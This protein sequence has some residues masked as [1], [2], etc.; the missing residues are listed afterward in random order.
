MSRFA[1]LLLLTLLICCAAFC[2]TAAPLPTVCPTNVLGTMACTLPQVYGATGLTLPNPFHRA[3]FEGSFE[4][5]LVTR[6]NTS[7][8]SQLSLLPLASPASGIV[9]TFDPALGV[10]TRSSQSFGPVLAERAETIGRRKLYL[11]FTYQRF[12]FDSIDGVDLDHYP[13]VLSHQDVT[14]LPI[15]GVLGVPDFERDVIVTTNRIDLRVSQF[16]SYATFGLTNRFDVSLAVP[17]LN[18]ALGITSDAT[19]VRNAPP[20][21]FGQNHFFI[22]GNQNSTRNVFH[23]SN[24]SSG[25]GDIVLRGKATAYRGERAGLAVGLDLRVPTGD[26]LNFR[27]SGAFGVR[28]FIAASYR[29][30][31]SPHVNLGYEWNGQSVLAGDIRTGQERNLPRQFLYTVGADVGVTRHVTVAADLLGQH[32][33]NAGKVR[34]TQ[35]TDLGDQNGVHHTFPD[36]VATGVGADDLDIVNGSFGLKINP[37]RGLLL[38]GNVLFKLN[39]AGLR[40]NVSPLVGISYTF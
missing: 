26:E 32:V 2:Q 22:P 25:I 34:L 16:T 31:V 13:A 36:A 28:P 33:F 39:E 9:F 38:S 27:G 12:H 18:V 5:T 24:S 6:L 8:A 35:F 11:A 17:V 14:N 10:A 30:R 20:G 40:D 21:P 4:S 1:S 3:H 15:I 37:W 19:V 23:T 7:I 29:A